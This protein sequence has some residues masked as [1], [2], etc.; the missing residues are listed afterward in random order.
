MNKWLWVIIEEFQSIFKLTLSDELSPKWVFKHSININN[1]KSVNINAYSLSQLQLNEQTKQIIK[2]M[3]KGLIHEFISLWGFLVLFI[4]KKKNT[5]W[6]CID[7]RALN[8]I[9]VKNEY[10]LL[11]IQ[12]CL[13]QI[14]KAWYLTKL[15]LT[16]SYYQVY[17]IKDDMKKT[18][19]NTYY[20]KYEFMTMFFKLCNAS[21]TFQLMMNSILQ[22]LLNKFYLIYLN[23]ILIFF[24]SIL[25]HQKHLWIIL[26]ILKKHKLYAKSS[27]CTVEMK[28]LKFCEHIVRQDTLWP[29]SIKISVI[30]NWPASKTAHHVQQFLELT[31]Y[32]WQFI[33]GFAWIA[34][35]LL[36]LLKK[37]NIKLCTKKN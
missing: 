11:W 21:T 16:L 36:D 19:F 24:N 3:N 34:A 23:N 4:K 2:L 17:V 25:N 22:N 15:N 28:I 26:N 37:N 1:I 5:W 35:L 20:S 9:T 12:K 27:K 10:S 14:D 29:V 13:D 32:Y 18:V 33:Q 7:Y 31:S 30:K 8:N 6:M